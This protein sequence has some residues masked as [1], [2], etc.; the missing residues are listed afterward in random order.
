MTEKGKPFPIVG[1]GASAGGQSALTAFFTAMA[2]APG[3]AFVLVQHLAPDHKSIL[4][5][6]IQHHTRMPVCEVVDGMT[7]CPNQVY[8]I[9]P[10]RDMALINGTLH[11]LAP[12]APRG[13]RL[14]IDF[15]FRS[16][17]QDQQDLAIGIILSGTG[18]DGTLGVRAIKGEGGLVIAQDPESAEYDGMPC[19]ASATGLVDFELRP[20]QMPERL[21]AYLE[22]AFCRSGRAVSSPPPGEEKALDKIFILLRNQTGHDFSQYKPST[23][24][25][26]IGRRMALQQIDTLDRYIAYAQQTPAE[27]TS[28]FRDLLIG[29]TQ[30][31]R[32]PEA[33]ELL[34]KLVFPKLIAG[35]GAAEA[36]RV[37][38]PGCSTGE[39]AYSLAILL[40]ECQEKLKQNCTVQIFATDID[41]RAIA[42]ARSG[43][44]PASIAADV[45][46]SRLARYFLA[47]GD[48]GGYRVHK[49]IRDMVIFS[50]QD[51]IK[52]PPFSRLDLI[53][54]R[55]LLI[56]MQGALQ[57][58][59]IPLFHC[60]LNP[61][62]FL[63]LGSSESIGEF[64][65]LFVAE[66]RKS[67]LYR[68]QDDPANRKRAR[69]LPMLA[70]G[71][72]GTLGGGNRVLHGKTPLRE[73][74]EQALLRHLVA[75]AALVH[76]NGDILYLHGRTGCY[77]EPAPG[78]SGINNL[79][80]MAREGLRRSL[81]TALHRAVTSGE[82]A[83]CPGLRVKTNGDKT[84]VNL[85]IF[86]LDSTL[87]G[88]QNM[89]LYLA[90][91]ESVESHQHAAVLPP[92][93]GESVAEGDP[94]L[95]ALHQEL[96]IKEEFLQTTNEE[97][98]AANEELMSSN[99]EMQSINEEL[100]SANEELETSKEE[101][102]SVN[103]ELTTVNGELQSKVAEL[104]LANNDMNNLLAGTGIGTVFVDHELRILRFTPAATRIINLIPGDIGR[105]VAH[106]VANLEGYL[107][108]AADVQAVLHSLTPL[109]VDVKTTAGSWYTMRIQPY[110]TLENV[111][112]GAVL[113]FVD[114]TERKRMEEELVLARTEAA[115]GRL[116]EAII[117]TVRE[118]LLVLDGELRV[119]MANRAF[120]RTF[121][122]SAEESV[123]QLLYQLDNGQWDIPALRELLGKILPEHRVF[124]GY[125][126]SSVWKHLGRRTLVLN[127]RQI[128]SAASEPNM[129]LLAIE[130]C[131]E[132]PKE[133]GEAG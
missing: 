130:E 15:F 48:G 8:V 47:E 44:Y 29:V 33:F 94:R 31:F 92:A 84:T 16:L 1:I 98:E 60:V 68:R 110:R 90:I 21:I 73:L 111:I 99:E 41:D 54:C 76:A 25:R 57:K 37:W 39:E 62:G 100:Q 66:D 105:P 114:I 75:A 49:T 26:R 85:T 125:E 82:M 63:F 80:K 17:A 69:F 102:Q 128:A 59:L 132:S 109:E 78:E 32:D 46:A 118:P 83:R 22:H 87:S 35:K 119:I 81:T 14:P 101:M 71:T 53:S 58:K 9:P 51:L 120:Y 12:F 56:Y 131:R 108:L 42:V 50:E 95:I 11:L 45:T 113:T 38:T 20:E 122:S 4:A 104:T 7:V 88:S 28:L 89:L 55:N 124:N 61:G 107:N 13:R 19:S 133:D 127:G 103:E 129:I 97:L 24:Q 126:V 106:T 40:A 2:D 23:L 72:R 27:L 6:L 70:R 115:Q 67:K 3:M 121:Q 77:L 30:F 123:G 86:P 112:E 36:I 43:F 116:A 34:E 79:L 93:P 65:D 52:D 10:N 74:V 64:T 18:S 91:F 5:E 117:S 96:Q